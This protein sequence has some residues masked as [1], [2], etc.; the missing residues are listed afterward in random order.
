MIASKALPLASEFGSLVLRYTAPVERALYAAVIVQLPGTPIEFHLDA[1]PKARK[2]MTGGREGIWWLPSDSAKDWLVL[3]NTSDSPLAAKLTLYESNGKDWQQTFKIGPRQTTRLSLRSLLQQGGLAGSYGGISVDAASRTADLDS[4]HFVYD[5]TRGF[6][7]LMKM[8]DRNMNATLS[9]RSLTGKQWTIRAPMLPL[10][11]PDPALALPPGTTLK[12]AIF[13]RNVSDKGCTAQLTFHWRSGTTT[14]KSTTAVP[15]ESYMTT[16]LDVAALQANGTIPASAQWAYVNITAPIKPDDLLAIAIS[17]DAAGRLGAQTPFTDQAANHWEG[18]MWE[19]DANHD[20]IIAVGNADTTASK[21]KITLYYNSGQAK[22]QVEP[23]LDH[24]EQVWLD[25]GKLI[26]DQVPDVHGTTI[27]LTVMSGSYE[28]ESVTDK[29]TD[30]LFEGKLVVDKTYGYA[31]HGC[32]LCCPHEYDERWVVQDP[33][34]LSSG[35]S[36]PQSVWGIDACNNNTVQIPSSGWTTGNPNVATASGNVITAAGVG[37]TSDYAYVTNHTTDSRGYCR[38]FSVP[39]F[40]TVNVAPTISGP[41]TVWW[42]N[43]QNPTSSYPIS[44]T[45]TSSG[46]SSTTWSVSQADAKVSLSPSTGSQ[47]TVTST[48]SHFSGAVGDISITATASGVSSAPFTMTARTPWKLS[49]KSRSTSCDPTYVYITDISYN[50]LDNL[51]S[52]IANDITWNESLGQCQSAN[53][54][55]WG[56]ICVTPGAGSTNP[57]LDQLGGPPLSDKPSPAPKCD[58]PPTGTTPYETVP[59]TIRVGSAT[60]G[61]GVLAQTDTLTYYLDQGNHT[62]IIVPPQPPQ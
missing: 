1:F 56:T 13:L 38:Y 17:F 50:V 51:S 31:V 61:T 3:T 57:L 20:T 46:G 34:N 22:Y 58:T 18:G 47:T 36:N 19:V 45:L 10:T 15:L 29:P 42:F 5:E 43:G 4:V 40:G 16:T 33:L 55:N 39:T 52:V 37:S 6:L 21:A 59:Q 14:G 30:G 49:L 25:I 53:G 12:P 24:D 44:V 54:S 11:N 27:P 60:T 26:R 62:G 7:A 41:N 35:G 28:L 2:P 9:E 8:F 32:A 23:T 48:G